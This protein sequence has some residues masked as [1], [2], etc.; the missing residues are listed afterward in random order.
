MKYRMYV[1]EVGNPDLE[2]YV[3]FLNTAACRGDVM[4]ESRG[5]KEDM[6]LKKSF[7]RIWK[8]GTEYVEANQFQSALTSRQLKVKVKANN[9]AGLQI[10][11]ILAHPSRIEI[12]K[13]NGMWEKDFAPHAARLIEILAI[14][15]HQRQGKIF[16]KKFI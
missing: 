16:G 14:K 10:A 2:R 8:K 13:E 4:A 3:F 7:T 9:I 6:R 11:D 15:Y 12:L 1:D 5:G